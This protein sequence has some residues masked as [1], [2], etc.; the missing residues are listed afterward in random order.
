VCKEWRERDREREKQASY[1][2]YV[3]VL[4]REREICQR[5]KCVCNAGEIERD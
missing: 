4:E 3:G 2:E 1:N 5:K